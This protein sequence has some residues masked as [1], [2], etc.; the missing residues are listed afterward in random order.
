MTCW[1]NSSIRHHVHVIRI[2]RAVRAASS[3]VAA[4]GSV[5]P[6]ELPAL[7]LRVVFPVALEL[8]IRAAVIPEVKPVPRSAG[9]IQLILGRG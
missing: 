6:A 5:N 2:E 8:A 7:V 3:S 1:T 9:H 4:E